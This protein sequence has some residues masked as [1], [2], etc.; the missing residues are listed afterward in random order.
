[1]AITASRVLPPSPEIYP[2]GGGRLTETWRLT[3]DG[4]STTVTLTAET[5]D[6]VEAAPNGT[7]THNITASTVKSVTLTF[8]TAPGNNLTLD[9]DLVGRKN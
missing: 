2:T 4:S 3:G 1:M 6:Y 9:V 5:L 7:I 8:A